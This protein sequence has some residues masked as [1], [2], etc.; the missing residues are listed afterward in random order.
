MTP[1]AADD[2]DTVVVAQPLHLP[3]HQHP[4]ANH[5]NFRRLLRFERGMNQVS[6]TQD[7]DASLNPAS[8]SNP[9][10]QITSPQTQSGRVR[11]GHP[12]HPVPSIPL[13]SHIHPPPHPFPSPH[14]SPFPSSLPLHHVLSAVAPCPD[15]AAVEPVRRHP[16]AP[17][18]GGE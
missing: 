12:L 17:H 6:K 13:K 9:P 8:Q 1:F 16:V 4:K 14:R 11:L 15:P 5:R 18:K 7:Q 10:T 2:S 3:E